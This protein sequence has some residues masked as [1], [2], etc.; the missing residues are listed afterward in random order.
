MGTE[1]LARYVVRQRPIVERNGYPPDVRSRVCEAVRTQRA[2][3]ESW[4]VLSDEFGLPTAT[5]KRWCVAAP[6]ASVAGF[7]P[8]VVRESTPTAWLCERPA[9]RALALPNGVQSRGL[10]LSDVLALVKEIA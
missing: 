5:L 10:T 4:R 6:G 2:S 9:G 1:E 8:V 7:V 3:G